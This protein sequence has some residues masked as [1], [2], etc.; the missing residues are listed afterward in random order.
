MIPRFEIPYM[1]VCMYSLI[2]ILRMSTSVEN[3]HIRKRRKSLREKERYV[4][5]EML[6]ACASL[7]VD[8]KLARH[9]CIVMRIRC[10]RVDL[11]GL[12]IPG[13]RLAPIQDIFINP[14]YDV[15]LIVKM[16][17]S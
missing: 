7:V 8:R 13:K 16:L 1:Y 4:F 14:I 9:T 15:G 10:H 11:S 3:I 6:L 5:I 12:T 17:K 2:H